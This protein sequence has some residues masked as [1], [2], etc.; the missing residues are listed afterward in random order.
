MQKYDVKA[1]LESCKNL[2]KGKNS[3]VH[4]SKVRIVKAEEQ[5]KLAPKSIEEIVAY[6]NN[7]LKMLGMKPKRNPV[8][9]LINEKIDYNRIK[10]ANNMDDKRDI[11]WMKFT[12][13]NYLGVVA[14]S[15][16]INFLIP[17]TRE[18]YNLKNNDKWMY[19]TSGIIVHHLNKLWNKNFVL[20]FPLVNIP[21]GLRRGDVE[22]GIG[23]YLISKNVPILDFYSHNY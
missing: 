22:R 16:D 3:S 17:K 14:T 23:N 6:T 18:Q 8:V 1:L 4:L 20:I 9:N 21:E 2:P 5:I 7:F 10:I 15:N 13:D 19:N 12:T 11:V